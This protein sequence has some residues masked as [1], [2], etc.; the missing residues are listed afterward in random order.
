MNNQVETIKK[1]DPTVATEILN[2]LG[3]RRFI[4]MTGSKN[5]VYDNYSLTMR[6]SR[7][8]AGAQYLKID[9]NGLDLYDMV[10]CSFDSKTGEKIVKAELKNIYCDGLRDSFTSVTGLYTSL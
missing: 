8:R 3:G 6:L 1:S 5:F 7:N 10:F 9:L 4:A 2:Q